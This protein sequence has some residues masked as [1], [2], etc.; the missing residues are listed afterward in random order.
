MIITRSI[1]YKGR[2]YEALTD[3]T[4]V[5]ESLLAPAS[6][7]LTNHRISEDIHQDADSILLVKTKQNAH[8]VETLLDN[9]CDMGDFVHIIE[10]NVLA[11][12]LFGDSMQE[13]MRIVGITGTNGKTTTSAILYSLLLDLGFRVALLGTRGFFI[14]D[15]MLKP[16]GLTTPSL[17]ELYDDLCSALEQKSDFFIM[18]V[19]SHA[20]I[21]ERIA[22]LTFALKILTN[23]TSDHLDYHKNI[24]EYRRVK[25]SFFEGNGIKLINADEPYANCSDKGAL[26]YGIEKKGHLSVDA[27]ALNDGIDAHIL[28]QYGKEK[29][30]CSIL[31]YLY[32]KHNL[33]N[34]L[35]AIAAAKILTHKHLESIATALSHFGGV[36]GRMEVVHN[37]PLVIVDFAH[38]YDGMYQIF[39]SFRHK[40]IVVVFGAGGD[41]D[42]SKRPKMGE[43]AQRFAHKVYITS[44]NPRTESPQNIIDDIVSGISDM[45]NICVEVDRKKA[46]YKALET[47][48]DDEVL[49]ILGKGDEDYQIIG[50]E[51]IHFDDREV[52]KAYFANK[53]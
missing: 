19:S 30:S 28:W 5:I 32:G 21:Q 12:V 51:K 9:F 15:A 50:A 41:R 17:L 23:I 37:K 27:Y 33:Y 44:D 47:L 29:E 25:N 13:K 39:E 49:L 7:T 8:F 34:V 2:V 24:D 1:K 40:K 11:D 26:Y 31:A 14:N 45:R 35:A 52:V 42:K 16:K 18:E 22:G 48:R 36:G 10:S 20:I 6:N 43:C 3:D 46:I 4:R 38:T 53:S